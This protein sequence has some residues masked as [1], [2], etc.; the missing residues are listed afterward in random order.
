MEVQAAALLVA[1]LVALLAVLL[2]VLLQHF[3]LITQTLKP[4][5]LILPSPQMS[6]SPAILQDKM[7]I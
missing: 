3:F 1:L 6:P 5:P 2:V 7:A 4:P